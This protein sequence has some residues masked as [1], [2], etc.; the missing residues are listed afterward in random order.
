MPME[1]SRLEPKRLK[2]SFLEFIV[3]FLSVVLAFF[4]DDFR[5]TKNEKEQYKEAFMILAEDINGFVVDLRKS[6]DTVRISTDYANRGEYLEFLLNL[7]WLDSLIDK[8]AATMNDF[9]YII[10]DAYLQYVNIPI[11][12]SPLSDQIG[13]RHGEH[14]SRRIKAAILRIYEMEMDHLNEIDTKFKRYYEEIFAFISKTDPSYNFNQ[15]DS[16]LFYSNEFRWQL[17]RIV[18]L[19]D[20]EFRYRE[21]LV[22]VRFVKIF[23][24]LEDEV[25]RLGIPIPESAK[26]YKNFQ[27]PAR[28]ECENERKLDPEKDKI[29]LIREM[30]PRYRKAYLA[31]LELSD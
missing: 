17:K 26:C 4:F 12:I 5:E 14:A 3:I 21:Y 1:N 24:V 15:A 13:T 10:D 2:R 8:E 30:V 22:E 20:Y 27:F 28:W 9:R 7:K 29:E 23:G 31:K 16:L 11:P 25:N 18:N 19:H 6:I